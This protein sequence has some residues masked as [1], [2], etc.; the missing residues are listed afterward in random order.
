MLMG[1]R[2]RTW[3]GTASAKYPS[4]ASVWFSIRTS[5]TPSN[6]SSVITRTR[7]R[8]RQAVPM[9]ALLTSTIFILHPPLFADFQT[10][11]DYLGEHQPAPAQEW[12]VRE[13]RAGTA[14]RLDSNAPAGP[15]RSS[16][17]AL[18]H[19]SARAIHF[20]YACQLDRCSAHYASQILDTREQRHV[21]LQGSRTI[22]QSRPNHLEP[23]CR[24]PEEWTP[25]G[26]WQ[27]FAPA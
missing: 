1:S 8:L 15:G 19:G 24:Y 25:P 20:R 13:R 26:E 11:P 10:T 3:F 27:R 22:E 23:P 18:A 6:P 5:P 16:H 9:T 12:P 7:V 21:P 4:S 17:G 14:R 2:P